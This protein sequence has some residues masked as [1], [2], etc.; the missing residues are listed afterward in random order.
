MNATMCYMAGE[1]TYS[2][3][4][5]AKKADIHRITLVRWLQAGRVKASREI[6]MPGGNV[7]R[8][9]TDA[10]IQKLKVYREKHYWKMPKSKRGKK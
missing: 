10:D 3:E 7:L 4:Q 6:Q 9:W 8:W 1:K 2:T 5:A